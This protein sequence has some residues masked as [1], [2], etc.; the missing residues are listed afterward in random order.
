MSTRTPGASSSGESLISCRTA[1]GGRPAEERRSADRT[2][3]LSLES[4]PCKSRSSTFA[5]TPLI[6]RYE[7][8]GCML[9]WLALISLRTVALTCMRERD[10]AREGKFWEMSA[11]RRRGSAAS[12]ILCVACTPMSLRSHTCSSLSADWEESSWSRKV[13]S[14]CSSCGRRSTSFLK[15]NPFTSPSPMPPASLPASPASSSSFFVSSM[16]LYSMFLMAS[17]APHP[18]RKSSSSAPALMQAPH[19][20][21]PPSAAGRST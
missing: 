12:A 4:R 10:V 3:A 17:S 20:E 14:S 18:G 9:F 6:R 16:A 1:A 19:L 11:R 7:E 21:H 15:M 5:S 13:T 2:S 8:P